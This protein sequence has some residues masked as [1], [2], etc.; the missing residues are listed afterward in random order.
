MKYRDTEHIDNR[1]GIS[2]IQK[3]EEEKNNEITRWN[4]RCQFHF[5]SMNYY[6]QI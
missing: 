4:L 3:Y 6:E 1:I 2:N 5:R